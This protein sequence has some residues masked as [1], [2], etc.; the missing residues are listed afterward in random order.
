MRMMHCRT[1]QSSKL[2]PIY[3]LKSRLHEH[4]HAS[5]RILAHGE[6]LWLLD[7]G[8]LVEGNST[9]SVLPLEVSLHQVNG[10]CFAA[11]TLM[12]AANQSE[13]N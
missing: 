3:D 2:D 6:S 8:H 7:Y 13:A 11:V 5:A 9:H 10:F 1:D 12:T 4:L